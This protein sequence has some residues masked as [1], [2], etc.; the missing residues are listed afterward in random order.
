MVKRT[1]PT[2][3]QLKL[4]IE[5]LEKKFLEGGVKLWRRLASDLKKPSRQ[6]RT[7]NI[8]KINKWS[9]EGETVVVPGKVLNLGELSKK[10][11]VAAFSFSDAAKE[12][13]SKVGKVMDIQELMETNPEGKKVRILG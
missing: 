1:G 3:F 9:R 8:Y 11:D 13:I 5:E 4:L 10:V 7:V 2:N 12:K 6:R